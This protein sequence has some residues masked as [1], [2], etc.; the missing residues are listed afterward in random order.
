MP[1]SDLLLLLLRHGKSRRDLPVQQDVER[2]LAARGQEDICRIARHAQDS[3]LV[4]DLIL[5]SSA[6]RTRQTAEL[7]RAATELDCDIVML[8]DL[9]L[10]SA[11]EILETVA[12]TPVAVRC[13]LVVGH[14][15][16]L[17][18]LAFRLANAPLPLDRLPTGALVGFAVQS[19]GW[20]KVNAD[21]TRLE[22]F[23]RPKTLR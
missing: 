16:G 18:T 2:P 12:A 3:A 23:V 5:C 9:Y 7:F 17:E 19:S 1:S 13:L 15:P 22:F 6:A 21:L 20:D 10:A 14:N 11:N 4:P 8:E